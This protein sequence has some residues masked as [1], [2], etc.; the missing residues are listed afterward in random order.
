MEQSVIEGASQ[1]GAVRFTP[2][3]ADVQQTTGLV[4]WYDGTKGYG[5]IVP[6]DGGPDIFLGK[7]VVA[8]ANLGEPQEGC[9]VVATMQIRA[10]GR[11]ATG[12]ISLEPPERIVPPGLADITGP[13]RGIVKLFNLKRGFGFIT[14]GDGTADIF[15]HVTTP[16]SNL[17]TLMAGDE[18]QVMWGSGPNGLTAVEVVLIESD[19]RILRTS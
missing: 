17:R 14:L 18:V 6:D 10:K 16:G 11:S 9:R 5:F 15:F 3:P 1:A 7:A 4:K 19:G 2:G 12:L 8:M 13:R